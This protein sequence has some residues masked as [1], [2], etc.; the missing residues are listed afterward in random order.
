MSCVDSLVHAGDRPADKTKGPGKQRLREKASGD[1]AAR[2]RDDGSSYWD[3]DAW[4]GWGDEEGPWV[5]DGTAAGATAGVAGGAAV[6]A[7]SAAGGSPASD[8]E[9][10]QK[11]QE[12]LWT[13]GQG[14]LPFVV[15]GEHKHQ[16][17][18]RPLRVQQ[19]PAISVRATYHLS[20]IHISEPTR[21]Y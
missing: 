18:Y 2:H 19:N 5:D 11:L 20:L 15:V 14:G 16:S 4:W 12:K 3:Q 17:C 21:P 8:E 6:G 13:L 1:R 7:A 9:S 10:K